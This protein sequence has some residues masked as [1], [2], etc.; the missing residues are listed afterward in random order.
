V[1]CGKRC[2]STPTPVT[3]RNN[4]SENRAVWTD[5]IR[6]ALVTKVSRMNANIILMTTAVLLAGT[7]LADSEGTPGT[8]ENGAGRTAHELGHHRFDCS[9]A[10]DPARC[11]ERGERMRAEVEAARKGCEGKRGEERR[12]CLINAI[13]AKAPDPPRC[14]E[15]A[16]GGALSA[17]RNEKTLHGAGM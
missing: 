8:S 5:N 6:V 2:L 1:P 17:T 4:F 3:I 13:C 16:R 7:A 10:P 11:E 14:S 9:H 12:T 15:G